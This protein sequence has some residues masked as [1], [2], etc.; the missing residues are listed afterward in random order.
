[1]GFLIPFIL[2]AKLL[3]QELWRCGCDWDEVVS[4]AILSCWKKWLDGAKHIAKIKLPRCYNTS[5]EP[6]QEV[7]L[8]LFCDA[9]ELAY[10]AVAYLRFSY[11]TGGHK[12]SFVMAKSK[13]APIKVITLPRL[14]LNSA[15]TAVRLFR[16]VIQEIALPIERICF[17]TDS[18]LT[19]QYIT[20]KVHRPKVYVAN[21]QN[22]VLESS[23]EEQ[24]RHI[25]G[26][27]NPADILTRGVYDPSTLLQPTK[28][29]T[30]WFTSAAFLEQDEDSWPN[31]SFDSL[32]E[33]DPELK[34]RTFL[35]ALGI[36]EK[37][38]IDTSKYSTWMTLK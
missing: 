26:K 8:H 18:V 5:N 22:E 23:T 14:E 30:S 7:Q 36:V 4:D 31:L 29:G 37:R 13:L 11:K 32:S 10:G 9:S 19:L 12:S 1:M 20:N 25:P 38:G 17:W 3:L 35:V 24:W 33:N 2:M 28:A 16:N 34:K 15:V 6:V 27:L 21:R